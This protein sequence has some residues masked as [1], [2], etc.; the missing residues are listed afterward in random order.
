MSNSRILKRYANDAVIEEIDGPRNGSCLYSRQLRVEGGGNKS[1]MTTCLRTQLPD[2]LGSLVHD[3]VIFEVIYGVYHLLAGTY[4]AVVT[5]SENWVSLSGLSIR[6]AKNISLVPI[7]ANLA[8]LGESQEQDDRR[9]LELLS[10]AF[11][12]HDFYYSNDFD[13]THSQ[14]RLAKQRMYNASKNITIAARAWQ[15]A[16]TRFFW[17]RAVVTPLVTCNADEWIVPFMNGHIEVRPDCVIDEH[18]F[19]LLFISRR[20]RFNQGCRFI[21]RGIDADGNVAN[22]VE[23]EQI[24][25]FQN[26]SINSYVQTRGSIPV[27]WQSFVHMKYAPEVKIDSTTRKSVDYATV[28]VRSLLENYSDSQGKAGVLFVNLIDKKKEQ[29]MLGKAFKHCIEDVQSST[30]SRNH[31][32]DFEWFDFHAETKRK[33][34][35][36]NLGALLPKCE[37]IF[38]AQMYFSMKADKTVTS[39]QVGCI[40]TNCMDNLDRTNVVQSL[41]ARRSILKQLNKLG[42]G[43]GD[44]L[45]SPY[46]SFEKIYKTVWANNANAISELYAGTGALKVDFTKTGKRTYKGLFNDGVNSCKRYFINNFTDG[47]KQDSIDILLGRYQ[48]SGTSGGSPFTGDPNH[49]DFNAGFMKIFTG[50]F[51]VFMVRVLLSYEKNN[52]ET[53]KSHMQQTL[54]ISAVLILV[55]LYML[56]K[57]GT[58]LGKRFVVRNCLIPDVP[59]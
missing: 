42:S 11:D 16:D 34:G 56:V 53:L 40:R 27:V 29:G 49:D 28:H 32:V 51:Y 54:L 10:Q 58:T 20:S 14:Q 55:L 3:S 35:W 46:T 45:N 38:Q 23:T 4:I 48:P 15:R 47:V 57:K 36:N 13:L 12:E 50:V 6:R 44:A 5:E 37:T 24:L 25:L 18:Q 1:E 39:W 7:F 9:Y 26:G 21:K 41:F 52:I 2:E 43:S 59:L 31:A 30:S 33:G 22:F 8:I 19:T 17:N